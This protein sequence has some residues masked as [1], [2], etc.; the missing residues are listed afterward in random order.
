MYQESIPFKGAAS[1]E[2]AFNWDE[3]LNNL[4]YN[5][6][7]SSTD[8][9]EQHISYNDSCG[10]AFSNEFQLFLDECAPPP[11]V[12]AYT[13]LAEINA[14]N[15]LQPILANRAEAYGDAASPS[16]NVLDPDVVLDLYQAARAIAPI[17]IPTFQFDNFSNGTTVDSRQ[18]GPVASA[19]ASST[20]R[21]RTPP[22]TPYGSWPQAEVYDTGYQESSNQGT[23][24]L[25]NGQSP[26]TSAPQPVT[27]SDVSPSSQGAPFRCGQCG[28][29]FD[30]SNDLKRHQG[31]HSPEVGPHFVCRCDHHNKRKDNYRRHVITCKRDALYNYYSCICGTTHTDTTIHLDHVKACRFG[32]H[33]AAGRP[34]NKLR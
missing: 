14:A 8:E 6:G 31:T 19:D 7:G 22:V 2:G 9:L 26:T 25:S 3:N 11:D 28:K 4:D 12:S 34:T 13:A 5:S 10:S 27:P 16:T 32:F 20:A 33:G 29:D 17:G 30:K 24:N 15:Q 21:P 1:L 18:Y 23:P